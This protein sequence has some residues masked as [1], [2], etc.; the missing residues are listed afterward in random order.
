MSSKIVCSS[1][2]PS[3]I[4]ILNACREL[5]QVVKFS[6]NEKGFLIESMDVFYHTQLSFEMKA[7][8]KSSSQIKTTYIDIETSSKLITLLK[9]RKSPILIVFDSNTNI[10][11]KNPNLDK[12][13]LVPPLEFMSD[14]GKKYISNYFI[15]N[16]FVISYIVADIINTLLSLCAGS[17]IAQINLNP[18]GNLS[19]L[20]DCESGQIY[21]SKQLK[22]NGANEYGSLSLKVIIKFVKAFIAA[23]GSTA[24][25]AAR[26]CTLELPTKNGYVKIHFNLCTD[27]NGYFALTPF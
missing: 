15:Q 1:A 25:D 16:S 21:I 18:T 24:T 9:E 22:N 3:F 12:I 6:T 23:A 2:F 11:I 7:L 13:D 14:D 27:V 8:D 19:Y 4:K 26:K 20:S 5:S 10:Y 17:G